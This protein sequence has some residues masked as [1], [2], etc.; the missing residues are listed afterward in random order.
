MLSL[1]GVRV[2]KGAQTIL[3]DVTATFPRGEISAIVGTNGSGKSTLLR[4]ILG[5]EAHSGEVT[6]DGDAVDPSRARLAYVEDEP[7]FLEGLTGS[8]N[9]RAFFGRRPFDATTLVDEAL[10]ARPFRSYSHGERMRFALDTMLQVEPDLL[11]MDEPT[12]GLDD[13]SRLRLAERLREVRD[14]TVVLVVDHRR[15]FIDLVAD[16]IHL[17]S[18]GRLSTPSI[19][20]R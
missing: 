2:E 13:H 17:L 18:D 11:L 7:R 3:S 4:C 8:Q 5:A 16:R 1:R 9:R 15:D 20:E 6:L 19:K 14:R 10:L 12:T